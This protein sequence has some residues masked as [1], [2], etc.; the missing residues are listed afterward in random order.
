MKQRRNQAMQIIGRTFGQEA[1]P[2]SGR[3]TCALGCRGVAN[4][5]VA[6]IT[7]VVDEDEA[8]PER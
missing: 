1:E 4:R 2:H 7:L 5:S 6:E 3:L 8:E